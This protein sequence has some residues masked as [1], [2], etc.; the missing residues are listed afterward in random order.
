MGQQPSSSSRAPTPASTSSNTSTGVTPSHGP[1][2]PVGG[3]GGASQLQAQLAALHVHGHDRAHLSPTARRR[4]SIQALASVLERDRKATATAAPPSLDA[5]ATAT[6]RP[7][8]RGRSHTISASSTSQHVANTLR[9][10]H[11]DDKM[12]N[13]QSR[14]K[15]ARHDLTP[16]KQPPPPAQNIPPARPAQPA[17]PVAPVAV[18]VAAPQPDDKDKPVPSSPHTRPV[19]VPAVPGREDHGTSRTDAAAAAAAASSIEPADASLDAFIVP[20]SHYSRPPRLPL[21]IEE[22]LVTPGSPIFSPADLTNPIHHDEGDGSLPRRTSMLSERNAD[23]DDL[24]DEFKGPQGQLT[25]P[26]LIEWE[27]AGERVYVTGTFAGWERK[28][29]LHPK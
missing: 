23:D 6:A 13:D 12:G 2:G 16:P 7:I 26:T 19:D 28:Y 3:V 25:V 27:G 24:A 29:Q 18:A 20:S 5:T 11:H 17:A 15:H 22:Q 1:H 10:H 9:A 21:P 8:S 14:P 4:E